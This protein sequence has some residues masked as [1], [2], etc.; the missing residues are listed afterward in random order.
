M[1]SL[2]ES[3]AKL[4]RTSPYYPSLGQQLSNLTFSTPSQT[5]I[6]TQHKATIVWKVSW[7]LPQGET[8]DIPTPPKI[9]LDAIK[10]AILAR[11]CN[12]FQSTGKK[13]VYLHFEDF[14][15]YEYELHLKQSLIPSQCKY[16]CC[17][18][19]LKSQSCQLKLASERLT[20]SLHI[21]KSDTT[22]VMKIVQKKHTLC[23]SV[24]FTTPLHKGSLPLFENIVNKYIDYPNQCVLDF[25]CV[26]QRNS[27]F[28]FTSSIFTNESLTCHSDVTYN[29]A[30]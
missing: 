11:D 19:Y 1:Y 5:N 4:N 28:L 3:I 8:R 30:W 23:W 17:L 18:L 15:N 24:P 6:S 14:L 7:I 22:Y 26:T 25:S 13:L 10:H 21:K 29:F 9:I 16:H 20:Q 12:S 2:E 27:L